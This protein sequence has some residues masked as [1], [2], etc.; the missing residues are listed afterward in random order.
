MEYKGHTISIEL[1]DNAT[2]PLTD[3]DHCALVVTTND[4]T[5]TTYYNTDQRYNHTPDVPDLTQDQARK[6][7]P[8]LMREDGYT[9]CKQWL[10]DY[11]FTTY[12]W[13]SI[14]DWLNDDYIPSYINDGDKLER[15]AFIFQAVGFQTLNTSSQGYSQGD[16]VEIL[17]V[18]DEDY[19]KLSGNNPEDDQTET[20]QGVADT[21]GAWAWGDV[22]G[23]VITKP[24]ECPHCQHDEPEE[25]D[26]CWGFYGDDHEKSG[27]LDQ[28]RS[29]IDEELKR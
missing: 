15:I 24:N 12:N 2:N 6:L 18:A 9:S 19:Y 28:A 1:D 21:Y 10:T 26:S 3:W 22:Y 4:N 23:Y 13:A 27:L 17:V 29:F 7:I 14:T 8:D 16:Y 25:V 11:C 20:L 5:H